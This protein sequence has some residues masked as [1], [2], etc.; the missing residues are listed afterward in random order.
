MNFFSIKKIRLFKSSEPLPNKKKTPPSAAPKEKKPTQWL[1]LT[2]SPFVYL[3]LFVLILA[4]FT[5]YLPS[6][7]L[8]SPEAG[9]I[10]SSDIIAPANL[11][12]EDRETTEKRKK[13]AVESV[14]PVYKYDENVFLN[15]EE[16]VREFFNLGRE[17][18]QEKPVTAARIEQFRNDV[19]DKFEK[20]KVCVGYRYQNQ[21]LA[22]FPA[23]PR[24]LEN[25]LPVYQELDG[26][27]KPISACRRFD[28][29]PLSAQDY[30][31]YVQEKCSVPVRYISVGIER[32]EMIII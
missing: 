25:C 1:K 17:W 28:Q 18:L 19:L 32:E 26:W 22:Q 16:K 8:P 29:L 27:H 13:E 31:R 14:H 24:V 10:A 6:K 21:I 12:I 11:T 2:Q 9:E 3:F 23:N 7:S 5:S 20:I 30:V 15:T 4:Y